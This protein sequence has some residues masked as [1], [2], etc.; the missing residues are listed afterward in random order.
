MPICKFCYFY[1]TDHSMPWLEYDV[2]DGLKWLGIPENNIC[3]A[4]R[5]SMRLIVERVGNLEYRFN[6]RDNPKK[7]P[8]YEEIN[9]ELRTIGWLAFLQDN[10]RDLTRGHYMR[11][12]FNEW[13]DIT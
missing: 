10:L 1:Q 5:H 8:S 11:K 4:C 2:S 12:R 7:N 13:R 3:V 6:V 9:L